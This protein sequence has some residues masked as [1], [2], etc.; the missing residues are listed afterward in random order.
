[1]RWLQNRAGA[2]AGNACRERRNIRCRPKVWSTQIQTGNPDRKPRAKMG[3]T[4][5]APY[6]RIRESSNPNSIPLFDIMN[7]E[8]KLA[9]RQRGAVDCAPRRRRLATASAVHLWS[10]AGQTAS[11]SR[12]ARRRRATVSTVDLRSVQRQTASISRRASRRPFTVSTV[13]LRSVDAK[14]RRS[15]AAPAAKV[16]PESANLRPKRPIVADG[17]PIKYT[18]NTDCLLH[19]ADAGEGHRVFSGGAPGRIGQSPVVF[20]LTCLS[21]AGSGHTRHFL[22]D[23]CSC[24]I[25]IRSCHDPADWGRRSPNHP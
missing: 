25:L 20:G 14:P 15:R 21:P 18:K 5:G 9:N 6:C 19:H 8:H 16:L 10:L 7:I 17:A 4:C 22:P 11:I 3:L 12:R 2:N 24:D 1:M 23:S 13:V